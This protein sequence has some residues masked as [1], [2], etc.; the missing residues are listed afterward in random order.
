MFEVDFGDYILELDADL[1]SENPELIDIARAVC[2]Q[3][4]KEMIKTP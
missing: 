3:T 2:I 1:V 4:L